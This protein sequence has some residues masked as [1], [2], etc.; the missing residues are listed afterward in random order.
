MMAK[1]VT[2]HQVNVHS[3]IMNLSNIFSEIIEL[4]HRIFIQN[5]LIIFAPKC[6]VFIFLF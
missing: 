6:V 1:E 5:M 2:G 3:L 4:E